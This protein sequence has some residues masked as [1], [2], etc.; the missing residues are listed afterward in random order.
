MKT[1]YKLYIFLIML[2]IGFT[3]SA[4]ASPNVASEVDEYLLK[5]ESL[6]SDFVQTAASGEKRFGKIFIQKPAKVRVEYYT[7]DKELITINDELAM[8]YDYDLEEKNYASPNDVFL[9]FLSKRNFSLRK[10]AKIISATSNKEVVKIVFT[11]NNDELARN[12]TFIFDRAI[13][14]IKEIIV[15]QDG[16]TISFA[17]T[18]PS[19]NMQI[20]KDLFDLDNLRLQNIGK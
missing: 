9:D 12:F 13:K 8:H 16:A 7:P 4:I 19:T 20:S 2:A 1:T 3:Q 6:K 18:N 11:I 10:N 17:L 14:Q 5:L 15:E